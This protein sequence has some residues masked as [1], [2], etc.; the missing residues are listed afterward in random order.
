[1]GCSHVYLPSVSACKLFCGFHLLI[2]ALHSKSWFEIGV[3]HNSYSR[4]VCVHTA[5]GVQA[6]LQFGGLVSVILVGPKTRLDFKDL[7]ISGWAS[8]RVLPPNYPFPASPSVSAWPTLA[9]LPGAEVNLGSLFHTLPKCIP[10]SLFVLWRVDA[11]LLK[12]I[13]LAKLCNVFGRVW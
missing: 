4:V 8:A 1:M 6:A 3:K 13:R 2:V 10:L 11:W 7:F 9:V 12:G 5:P